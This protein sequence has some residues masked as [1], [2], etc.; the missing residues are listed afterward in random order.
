MHADTL[1]HARQ[2]AALFSMAMHDALLYRWYRACMHDTTMV[3]A[4]A[5]YAFLGHDKMAPHYHHLT[6]AKQSRHARAICHTRVRKYAEG[7]AR[8]H[9]YKQ[10]SRFFGL[11]CERLGQCGACHVA[12]SF[13]LPRQQRRM[14][15][16]PSGTSTEMIIISSGVTWLM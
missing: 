6:N 12:S 15:D 14:K 16:N 3:H 9:T 5:M 8:A 11:A 2:H 4:C 13:S 7:H 1:L 10:A